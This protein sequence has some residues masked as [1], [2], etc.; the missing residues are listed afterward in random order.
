MRVVEVR[1]MVYRGLKGR[2][3]AEDFGPPGVEVGVKVYDADGTV[4]FVNG[5]E[6][7]KRDG[8]VA[9]EGDDAGEG[10]LILGRALLFCICGRCAHE[11]TVVAFFDLLDCVG[12][13]VA[14]DVLML[15]ISSVIA[16]EGETH[17]VTGISPQSNTVAQLLKGL[18]SSGTL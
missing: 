15:D 4:G 13:V 1:A 18:A 12:I 11:E 2:G 17:D 8:V 3:S 5:A 6:E 14:E 7:G 16:W 10:L 9:T